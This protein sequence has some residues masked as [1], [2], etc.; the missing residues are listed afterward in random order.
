MEKY[1]SLRWGLKIPKMG[2]AR[3]QKENTAGLNIVGLKVNFVN[4]PT[5]KKNHAQK[6]IMTMRR[7]NKFPVQFHVVGKR[8][9]IYLVQ[10][11]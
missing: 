1:V 6:K 2:L 7:I 10:F 8:I 5:L 3:F 4:S 11:R 9:D